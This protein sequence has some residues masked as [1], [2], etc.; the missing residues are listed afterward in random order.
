[1]VEPLEAVIADEAALA[2]VETVAVIVDADEVVAVD[3]E[4]VTRAKRRNGNQL[5]NSDVL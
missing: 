3:V 2:H 1:M 5:R 4:E